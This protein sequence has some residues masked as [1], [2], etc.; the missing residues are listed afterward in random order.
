MATMENLI[1]RIEHRAT[2][3]VPLDDLGDE[4]VE[5][6]RSTLS[7]DGA[8]HARL[9]YYICW[10]GAVEPGVREK[11]ETILCSATLF[12]VPTLPSATEPWRA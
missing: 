6:L 10:P 5:M 11:M 4:I 2:S 12:T 3:G 9:G 8:F 7:P 1:E